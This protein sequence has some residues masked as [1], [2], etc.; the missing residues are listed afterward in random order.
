V[1]DLLPE[2]SAIWAEVTFWAEMMHFQF[3]S[4]L[5]ASSLYADRRD[6]ELMRV[7]QELGHRARELTLYVVVRE[8]QPDIWVRGRRL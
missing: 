8:G 6:G 4:R 1:P 5:F 2:D 3:G 7:A